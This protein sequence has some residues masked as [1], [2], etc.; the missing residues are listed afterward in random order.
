M[1]EV[2]NAPDEVHVNEDEPQITRLVP[3][4]RVDSPSVETWQLS[5]FKK[6]IKEKSTSEV[7]EQVYKKMQKELEPKLHQQAE[8]LKKEAYDKAFQQGY[9]EGL[10][11]GQEEGAKQGEAE[12]KSNVMQTLEPK[13][14]QFDSIL[15]S[16]KKPYD[17]LEQKLYTE[18]VDFALHIANTVV[19]KSVS[20]HKDWVTEAVKEAVLTLPE[21]EGKIDVYLHPDDLA[22]IQISKP[23]ISEN[24]QLHEAHNVEVGTCLV[25]QDYS[26]VVNSWVARFDDVAQKISQDVDVEDA[27]ISAEPANSSP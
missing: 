8:V 7:S 5:S 1:A 16:L 17:V 20:E 27:P 2:T 3:S 21:S 14:E 26:T 9:E 22:F 6:D 11:K 4:S 15:N 12:A 10:I 25:K 18:V 13:I 19:R 24:W 23:S